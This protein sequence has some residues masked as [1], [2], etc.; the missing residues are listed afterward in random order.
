VQSIP[1]L[2]RDCDIKDWVADSVAIVAAVVVVG[3][4]IPAK[5]DIP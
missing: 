1:A 2:H 4:L 3:W 5:R